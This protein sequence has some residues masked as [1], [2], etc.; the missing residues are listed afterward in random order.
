MSNC[1]L[2]ITND[3]S[4]STLFT[5]TV[6]FRISFAVLLL[7]L[8][9]FS[10]CGS[11]FVFYVIKAH[12]LLRRRVWFYL[13]ILACSDGGMSLFATPIIIAATYDERIL[14]IPWLCNLSGAST[15]FFGNWS[16]L[17]MTTLSAYKYKTINQFFS[18]GHRNEKIYLFLSTG[19]SLFFA[20]SPMV[21]FSQYSYCPDR[22]WCVILSNESVTDS[23]FLI[24]ISIFSYCVPICIIILTSCG[25][26]IIVKKQREIKLNIT[27]ASLRSILREEYCILI[28]VVLLIGIFLLLWSPALIYFI[29]GMTRSHVPL[30]YSHFVYVCILLQGS[31][32][33][34]VYYYKHKSF[35]KEL[36]RL[37]CR[38]DECNL[39]NVNMEMESMANL[40]PLEGKFGRSGTGVSIL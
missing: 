3:S 37:F 16:I 33:P 12:H 35:K 39:Q 22:K 36:Q 29:L 25:I 5:N 10:I 4:D 18:R 11:C 14:K 2:R 30:W 19:I 34:V 38:I 9:T 21:G 17:T 31:I 24:M 15:M 1:S 27:N 7:L 40:S 26:Y 13:L 8:F 28:T 20:V 6:A 32:N 23:V